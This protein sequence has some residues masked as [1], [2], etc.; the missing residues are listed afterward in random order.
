M[1]DEDFF[2]GHGADIFKIESE[3][4]DGASAVGNELHLEMQSIRIVMHH[5]PRI[6]DTKPELVNVP[7]EYDRI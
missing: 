1:R 6:P 5:G 3:Q 4:S 2:R 7:L